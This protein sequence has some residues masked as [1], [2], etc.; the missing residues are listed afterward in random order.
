M[1]EQDWKCRTELLVTKEGIEKLKKSHVLIVGVGGVGGATA[2]Q[3][4][5]AGVGKLT[6]VDNDTI[7]HSNINRQIIALT[8]TVGQNKCDAL[9]NRLKLINPEVEI[10]K[11]SVFIEGDIAKE[12]VSKPYDFIVD[13]ID[14]LT[15]KVDLLEAC[16]LGNKQ[17]V[18][19]MGSGARLDPSQVAIADIEKTH[20]C[21]LAY[22][23]RK[24]L[25]RRGIRNGITAVFSTEEVPQHALI[26]TDGSN[27]KRTVVGT[28]S[29]MPAI[30]GAFCASVV[31]RSI[32]S[33]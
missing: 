15:P 25:H 31:I 8:N 20:H 1:N 26:E 5:R 11:H 32:L 3:I 18:S 23:V 19:S 30:F 9:E 10:E 7:H 14:T 27:N 16:V 21:K 29:Y 2:E 22:L 17:V 13:A 24:Y 12:L 28:M 6:I 4:C 33:Q